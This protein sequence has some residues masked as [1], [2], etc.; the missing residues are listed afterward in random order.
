[1]HYFVYLIAAG[2]TIGYHVL[3]VYL[4]KSWLGVETLNIGIG[5]LCLVVSFG[6]MWLTVVVV[7]AATTAIASIFG[8][9]PPP[10]YIKVGDQFSVTSDDDARMLSA[11]LAFQ[12]GKMIAG[13]IDWNE[14]G[15][16]TYIVESVEEPPD[17]APSSS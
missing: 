15:T 8:K 2:I 14:D 17:M 5:F 6:L 13:S 10:L 12:S 11:N 9:R 4:V 3:A 16:G 1:M 7:F